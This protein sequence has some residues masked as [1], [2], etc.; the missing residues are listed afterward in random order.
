M[1]D[2]RITVRDAGPDDA[3]RI[4]AIARASWTDTYRDIFDDAFIED[5]LAT[6]YRVED[7]AAGAARA[8]EDNDHYFLV[9]ERAGEVVAFAQFAVGPRGPQL[10]RIYAD[11]A[12]YGI[13]A[14]H[15]LIEE[16]HRRLG[17]RFDSYVLDVHPRNE[18]GLA[19]YRRHGFVVAGEGVGPDCHLM[20][21][22]ELRAAGE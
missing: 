15:A 5:S 19:F 21:R 7:L 9:A 11:P 8:A 20:L 6:N 13:G 14:G 10:F 12:H 17:G 1:S 22:R 4:A 2:V 3:A 18:R 16:L